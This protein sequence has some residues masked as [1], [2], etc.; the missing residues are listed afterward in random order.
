MVKGIWLLVRSIPSTTNSRSINHS[1]QVDIELGLQSFQSTPI[2]L[3]GVELEE[4]IATSATSAN[5]AGEVDSDH[6]PVSEQ[7]PELQPTLPTAVEAETSLGPAM[8][9]GGWIDGNELPKVHTE[10]V[11]AALTDM[12]SQE[13]L[14]AA[15]E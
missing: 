4:D 3:E 7:R 15:N 8:V 14:P 1:H 2:S 12:E 13:F 11:Q 6:L 9:S 5:Q 10:D